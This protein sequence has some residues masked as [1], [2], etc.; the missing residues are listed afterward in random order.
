MML[1]PGPIGDALMVAFDSA[2][3]AVSAALKVQAAFQRRNQQDPDKPALKLRMGLHCGEVTVE[4]LDLYG[5]AVNLASRV[6]ALAK[7]GQV[8]ATR[9]AHDD[10]VSVGQS[11]NA[12]WASHG[13]RQLK[14][15]AEPQEIWEVYEPAAT[16]PKAPAGAF[17]HARGRLFAPPDDAKPNRQ[18]RQPRP[19]P[20]PL[21]PLQRNPLEALKEALAH[22]ERRL[23]VLEGVAGSGKT[24][25]ASAACDL[26]DRGEIRL[27]SRDG[28]PGPVA[29]VGAYI[30]CRCAMVRQKTAA[31]RILLRDILN[32]LKD[33][34]GADIGAA[35]TDTDQELVDAI[36]AALSTTARVL[37]RPE[38]LEAVLDDEGKVI[39]KGVRLFFQRFLDSDNVHGHR[40]LATSQQPIDGS[41][42]E[43]GAGVRTVHVSGLEPEAAVRYLLHLDEQG[44]ILRRSP[45][46]LKGIASAVRQ[47]PDLLKL[48][49][50]ELNGDL[51]RASDDEVLEFAEQGSM[52]L[53]AG[54]L[55]RL[56]DS[57]SMVLRTAAALDEPVSISNLKDVCRAVV[58]DPRVLNRSL[59]RLERLDLLDYDGRVD[60]YWVSPQ[61]RAY[62]GGAVP[63]NEWQ[64]VHDT[65]AKHY[66]ER[67]RGYHEKGTSGVSFLRFFRF[68]IPEALRDLREHQR[69]VALG[70]HY[71]PALN[72]ALTSLESRFWWDDFIRH[73]LADRLLETFRETR[74]TARDRH[75]ATLLATLETRYPRKFEA[76]QYRTTPGCQPR[77]RDVRT[78]LEGIREWFRCDGAVDRVGDEGL[79]RLR[80]LT[81][82]YVA[83][84][85]HYLGDYVAC[86]QEM[87]EGIG[88]LESLS[89]GGF[90]DY[91]WFAG[92]W[93]YEWGE[94]K[95]SRGCLQEALSLG[96]Q[97][98][99]CA[100][101]LDFELKSNCFGLFGRLLSELSGTADELASAAAG[102]SRD[103]A[104]VQVF[105]G[106]RFAIAPDPPDL[107]NRAHNLMIQEAISERLRSVWS[108]DE[109]AAVKLASQLHRFW[110]SP[111]SQDGL[112]RPVLLDAEGPRALFAQRET[113]DLLPELFPPQLD[114]PDL[115]DDSR[116][117]RYV[118][119]A[120]EAITAIDPKAMRLRRKVL[121]WVDRYLESQGAAVL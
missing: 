40:I 6:S 42:S 23:I 94:Y 91:D 58:P 87:R 67:I 66:A 26:I 98:L 46:T 39:P 110:A 113:G 89:R 101:R 88:M 7:G 105:Y 93:H 24:A 13:L 35:Q 49:G 77:W 9:R 29:D 60:A 64:D 12:A 47:N 118:K 43:F 96:K 81:G 33:S 17:G 106:L 44:D 115:T 70:G 21:F 34:L 48:L 31:S 57:M 85:C 100:E 71:D 59:T 92:W 15:I 97:G 8:F 56:D 82:N 45:D 36:F 119:E 112:F 53:L 37:L 74:R 4:N 54:V 102:L 83:E 19:A 61:V 109:G 3:A 108:E 18:Y 62:L 50:T 107:Y 78:A 30:D 11:A 117:E 41:A 103:A 63:R 38:N 86:D 10:A 72:L 80:V 16:Q 25:V 75:L 27:Q 28:I 114:E 104:F 73:E 65:C 95:A 99:D 76:R 55:G 1:F 116:V 2:S 111:W 14:G 84:A 51:R 69:H 120:K 20:H 52:R 68:E 22:P 79:R 5:Q 32:A 90:E 121:T